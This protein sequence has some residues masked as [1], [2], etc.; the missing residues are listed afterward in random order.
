MNKRVTLKLYEG[1]LAEG[2]SVILQMGDEGKSPRL[3]LSGKLPAAPALSAQFQRWQRAYRQQG[4]LHSSSR[5]KAVETGLATNV[6]I[7]ED[8]DRASETLGR[9]LNEWLRSAPFRPIRDKLL[10]RLNPQAT[11]QL[12]LQTQDAITQRLPWH[13]WEICS[14]YPSLEIALSAPIYDSAENA[15]VQTRDRRRILAIF[16]SQAD[17]DIATDRTLLKEL[18]D[19][20][21]HYLQEPD[22]PT[23][24]ACLWDEQGWDILFF[25]G[26]SATRSNI[27]ELSINATET[28]TISQLKH[29]LRKA[30][31]RGL[32]IA[33][34][35]SCDGLGLA[36]SLC[37]L[38]LSQIVVMREVVADSVAHAFLK[39]FLKAFSRGEPL[40]LAVREARE[41][42]LGL[43]SQFPC[44]SWLPIIYQNPAEISPS[45]HSLHTADAPQ[46]IAHSAPPHQ[47][48]QPSNPQPSANAK[49]LPF[50]LL[51][52]LGVT[53]TLL[54]I[55]SLS[56]FQGWEMKM[57]DQLMRL[58]PTEG[59]DSRIVV[60]QVTAEDVRSQPAAERTGSLSDKTLANVLTKLAQMQ[61]QSIGL[62]I[63]RDYPVR[64][65]QPALKTALAEMENLYVVC[66]SS[67][68]SVGEEGIPPPPEVP[69]NR[70]GFSD[71]IKDPDGV[72][73]RQ[74]ISLKPEPSSPCR[75]EL[76][77]STYLAM[78]YLSEAGVRLET[79]ENDLFQFGEVVLKD[80]EGNAGGYQNVEE[81]G[82]QLLLNYRSLDNPTE[83][84][85]RVTLA[86]LLSGQINESAIRD[87]IVLIG[88]TDNSFTDAWATPY[89]RGLT[90][91]TQTNGVFL[92][93]HMIS[94][95]LS[96]G[97]N[98]R[99]FLGAWPQ[100]GE[101]LW[102]LSWASIG[103]LIA[104]FSSRQKTGANGRLLLTLLGA[105]VSLLGLCWILLTKAHTWVPW[106]PSAIAPV[107]VVVLEKVAAEKVAA[108]KATMEKVIAEKVIAEKI[109]LEKSA[110][111]KSA[112]E[113]SSQ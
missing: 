74:L 59:R 102:L 66:K 53:L 72:L 56:W 40:Y 58:R 26:H 3:E 107:A 67:D 99:P 7:V 94:Q 82:Y 28:I 2:F 113:K 90:E 63:Y 73:R 80:L 64:A 38:R 13:L 34:F 37:D 49:R 1:S 110:A 85:D 69:D 8:C 55:Q 62:D 109:A 4:S 14:L 39:S 75:S 31:S 6:A 70:V 61:P 25:A 51:I 79:L 17:L 89:S 104:I 47:A 30:V 24:D 96:A 45:W 22:R 41:R 78:R 21:I 32:K 91:E 77:L 20:E 54:G 33:I 101:W 27:G 98:D 112:A 10:E 35:N 68:A 52:Q 81:E 57:F 18:P 105:E 48:T 43:E 12:I 76:N 29:S 106:V 111:K 108:E 11:T 71:A 65:D 103:G 97:L 5:I 60:V 88:I 46:A 19:A 87:R 50:L 15:A 86:E 100:W 9:L 83:I 92:Q 95:L 93:A 23:L 44:A 16:G 42:L 84:A 36:Q